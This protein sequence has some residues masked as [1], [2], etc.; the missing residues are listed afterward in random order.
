VVG[1]PY[2]SAI[3]FHKVMQNSAN[4]S[5]AFSDAFYLWDPNITGINAV[6]GWVAM[7]YNSGAGLY[8]RNVLTGGSTNISNTGDIQSGSAFVIDYSGAATYLRIQEPNKTTGSN[9]TQFR[10]ARQIRTSLLAKNADNSVSVNDAALVTFDPAYRNEADNRDMT[11]LTNFAENFGILKKD[12]ILVIERRL[13]VKNIDTIFYKMTQMKQKNYQLEFAMEDINAPAGTA[14]FLEDA[15]LNLK[16]PISLKDTSRY[17][18]SITTSN[19][20]SLNAERFRLIFRPS[21]H[22]LDVSGY[23]SDNDI[24]V[25]WK[26]EDEININRFEI[27]RSVDGISFTNAAIINAKGQNSTIEVKYNWTDINPAPGNYYYR[28][29]SISNNDVIA[30]SNA[31]NIKK[32]NT[33]SGF[34]VF[35]NPAEGNVIYLQMN[36]VAK[37]HYTVQLVSSSG[38]LMSTEIISYTGGMITQSIHTSQNLLSGNYQLNVTGPDKKAL[39][40][41]LVV[42]Q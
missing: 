20:A 9:L 6:G 34:Y 15:F 28:I 39:S 32:V 5:G 13:P 19:S 42:Q 7:S 30:Y 33:R 4:V 24:A 26:I 35:P 17:D 1:N 8:D 12:K 37:G 10:P 2:P 41:K 11:K 16:I 38:E 36:S 40:L 29:K 25:D 14:V 21:V 23:L 27:E 22:Y 3:N 31:V 18:F